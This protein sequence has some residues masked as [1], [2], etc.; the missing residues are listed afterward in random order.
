MDA[1]RALAWAA[2]GV[3]GRSPYVFADVRSLLLRRGHANVTIRTARAHPE[4]CAVLSVDS[5]VVAISQEHSGWIRLQ[6]G[7]SVLRV[8]ALKCVDVPSCLMDKASGHIVDL[9]QYVA[10]NWTKLWSKPKESADAY[11]S[12]ITGYTENVM[13]SQSRLL[14]ASET[15]LADG[16]EALLHAVATK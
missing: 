16:I 15:V 9:V 7:D 10:A 11:A 13:L 1:T 5:S 2:T 8:E 12:R 4:L 3:D 14:Y 6:L